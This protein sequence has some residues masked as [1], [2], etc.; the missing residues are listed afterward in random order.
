VAG[1]DDPPEW[2]PGDEFAD[3]RA[4]ALAEISE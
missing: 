1:A 2:Y 4:A 3:E